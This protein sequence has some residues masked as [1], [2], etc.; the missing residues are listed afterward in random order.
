MLYAIIGEDIPH[1]LELRLRA[2]PAHQARLEALQADG[3]LVIAGPFPS[4]D[5]S[6]PGPAGFSGSLIVAEFDSLEA[7][8]DWAEKDPYIVTGAYANVVVKA[9]RQVYPK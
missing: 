8:K 7:A 2:R 9:F 5:A 1:S 6:D 4:I 3:R